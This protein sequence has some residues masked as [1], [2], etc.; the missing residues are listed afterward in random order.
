MNPYNVYCSEDKPIG[1][2]AGWGVYPMAVAD[3]LRNR[4]YQVHCV[5]IHGH[6]DQ[7]M[8]TRCQSF[9]E[10]GLSRL[11][12]HIRFL[13]RQRV[14]RAVF[15]G[16]IHKTLFFQPGFLRKNVP[17]WQCLR[18]YFPHFVSRKKDCADNSLL[19]TAVQAYARG[20][21]EIIGATTLVP[22]LLA[23]IEMLG[24][25]AISHAQR[26]DIEFG[27]KLAE[28]M[29]GLDIGQTVA[30]KGQAVLA[31]EAVEGTDACIRRAGSLC[32]AG[33]FTVVK[34]AK[35]NQDMRFDVPT[36]GIGTLQTLKQSGAA[37]LAIE[38]DKTIVIDQPRVLQYARENAISLVAIRDGQVTRDLLRAA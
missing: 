31:V 9:R 6:V 20:G 27:W 4:D 13:R 18:A 29:G 38:A 14:R 21:I 15:A 16:K 5:G 23:R 2:I 28:K 3:A 33:G 37:V 10:I 17:D 19:L 35:P 7:S 34:V 32:P 1:L 25:R 24:S 8:S 26:C 12:A 36:I 30:V 22:E 11:G